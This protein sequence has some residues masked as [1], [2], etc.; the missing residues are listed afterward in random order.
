MS[1]WASEG[2]K[3]EATKVHTSQQHITLLKQK[4]HPASPVRQIQ[5]SHVYKLRNIPS[6]TEYIPS[7]TE[8]RF[9]CYA[10]IKE[11]LYALL[12][13]NMSLIR[14]VGNQFAL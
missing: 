10:V 9:S 7:Y 8:Y 1:E 6:Y 12:A 14:N 11:T 13:C 5:P 2:V 3:T 4:E